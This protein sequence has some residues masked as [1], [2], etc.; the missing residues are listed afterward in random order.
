MNKLIILAISVFAGLG[1]LS[2]QAASPVNS[3]AFN[4][5][6]N[7]TPSCTL[8]TPTAVTINYTG[9]ATSGSMTSST[10]SSTDITCTS[11]LTYTVAL[12]TSP[13]LVAPVFP[14]TDSVVQIAYT[15]ALGAP[16]GGGTGTAIAQTYTI[17]PS[18]AAN[19]AGA[20]AGAAVAGV[21][22]NTGSTN[23]A[24]Y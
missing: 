7:L 5:D 8:T 14:V 2:A 15:L 4:V 24:F 10:P 16:T 6:I 21:C 23:N 9:S 22:P 19:Q 20:C 18:A 17:T 12:L 13:G 11:G 1:S 3:G